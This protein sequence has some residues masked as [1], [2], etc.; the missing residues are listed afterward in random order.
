MTTVAH[1]TGRP[2]SRTRLTVAVLI[3][4]LS[5]IVQHDLTMVLVIAVSAPRLIVLALIDVE[6][7]RL[8]DRI[9][10]PLYPLTAAILIPAGIWTDNADALVRAAVTASVALVGYAILCAATGAIGFGDV[11]LA[12]LLGLITGWVGWSATLFATVAAMFLGAVAGVVSLLGDRT[13]R[14]VPYGPA[15][16]AAFPFGL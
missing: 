12:G 15:L 6:I 9:L 4:C 3:L 5:L 16:I 2:P 13:R 8:P 11:K 14:T 7:R 10:L 1:Y